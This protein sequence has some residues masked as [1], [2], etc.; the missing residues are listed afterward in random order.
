MKRV[1]SSYDYTHNTLSANCCY[2]CLT[3]PHTHTPLTLP[4]FGAF[5]LDLSRV[6]AALLGLSALEAQLMDPQQR[7]LME[8]TA[9]LVLAGA[10]RGLGS[11]LGVYVGIASS[12]YGTLVKQHT[13]AGGRHS[14]GREGQQQPHL[15]TIRGHH[16]YNS[17]IQASCLLTA[18]C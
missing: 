10:H 5:L 2:C 15:L 17:N 13:A 7:L 9:E 8:T 14:A 18:Y 11:G 1:H 3:P 16:D 6:D 12:D 4:R